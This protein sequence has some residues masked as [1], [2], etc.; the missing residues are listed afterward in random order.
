[1]AELEARVSAQLAAYSEQGIHRTGTAVD[2]AS[3]EWL[4]AELV[5]AGVPESSITLR[6]F[7]MER[8][9]EGPAFL[10]VEGSAT[11][12]G[13]A[14]YDCGRYTD[15]A[16]IRGEVGWWGSDAD[17]GV[18]LVDDANDASDSVKLNQARSNPGVHKV[19]VAGLVLEGS[20]GGL[21]LGNAPN[22]SS[23]LSVHASAQFGEEISGPWGPPVLQLSTDAIP[24]LIQAV[25]S[26][27]TATAVCAAHRTAATAFNVEATLPGSEPS[28][29]PVVVITPRSGWWACASERGP[30]C[31]PP[32]RWLCEDS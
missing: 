4:A 6:E 20:M 11:L 21:A 18:V 19:I 7:P 28:L 17:I 13:L 2:A 23:D 1:M 8:L 22:F 12:G 15:V 3:G 10:A 30:V 26:G 24:L 31:P 32:H 27:S 14:M 29:P 16:G 9:D 25:E 5:G